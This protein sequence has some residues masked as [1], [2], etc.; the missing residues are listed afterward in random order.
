MGTTFCTTHLHRALALEEVRQALEGYFKGLGFMPTDDADKADT[1]AYISQKQSGLWTTIHLDG[2]EGTEA[3]RTSGNEMSVLFATDVLTTAVIGSDTCVLG[4]QDAT[5]ATD[6]VLFSDPSFIDESAPDPFAPLPQGSSD[7][8]RLKPLLVDSDDAKVLERLWDMELEDERYVFAED[9]MV[10]ILALFGIGAERIPDYKNATL[11]EPVY[12][13][14]GKKKAAGFDRLF[15]EQF[16]A[17]L[18]PHGFRLLKGTNI[19]ARLVGGEI[20]QLVTRHKVAPNEFMVKVALKTVY[21]DSLEMEY[22]KYP[23]LGTYDFSDEDADT[24]FYCAYNT[25]LED[26]LARAAADVVRYVLPAFDAARDAPSCIEYFKRYDSGMLSIRSDPKYEYLLLT[27]TRNRDDFEDVFERKVALLKKRV[28]L[29]VLG[30]PYYE[31]TYAELRSWHDTL[32]RQRD[33]ILNDPA[34][35]KEA[36]AEAERRRIANTEILR[37]YGFEV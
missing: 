5:T 10:D 2:V 34:K 16:K 22:L 31:E 15:K 12:L 20:L 13:T 4:Y 27:K 37:S 1:T 29:G 23:I 11:W 30:I 14:R 3:M 36:D 7:I 24:T 19:F 33:E 21:T 26:V 25:T 28:E 8:T 6:I 32:V 9:R 17:V 18:E 35:L